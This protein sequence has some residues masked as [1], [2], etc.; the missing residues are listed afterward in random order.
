MAAVQAKVSGGA[1]TEQLKDSEQTSLSC[2]H[3][4]STRKGIGNARCS[5]DVLH[6]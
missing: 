1:A 6:L 4:Y 2:H 5:R 3:R